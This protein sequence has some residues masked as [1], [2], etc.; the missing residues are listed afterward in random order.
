MSKRLENAPPA[1]RYLSVAEVAERLGTTQRFPRRLIEE[2]R[3]GFNVSVATYASPRGCPA[4]TSTPAPCRR[5]GGSGRDATSVRQHPAPGTRPVPSSVPRC[6][7][8]APARSGHLRHTTQG[9]EVACSH[10]GRDPSRRV[11]RSGSRLDNVRRVRQALGCRA[12]PQGTNTG[13]IRPTPSTSRP[14]VPRRRGTVVHHRRNDPNITNRPP[15]RGHRP[16]DR[17]EDV[18][19]PPCRVRTSCGRSCSREQSP[20]TRSFR[21]VRGLSHSVSPSEKSEGH[22]RR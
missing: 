10:R 5:Q 19:H 1:E 12:G 4:S 11:G 21:P 2:R 13:G 20:W 6:R 9:R 14:P 7:W 3:I 15:G 18:P 22:V 16:V 8:T 17:D